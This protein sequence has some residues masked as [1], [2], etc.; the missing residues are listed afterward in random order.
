MA[1][2]KT[3]SKNTVNSAN[4]FVFQILGPVVDVKFSED[5]I[6]MI[7]DALVVDNNGVELVLEVEQHMGDEVVRTIAMGP[8][9]GLAK[10]LPVINTNAPIQAPVGDDVLGRMFNVTGH[11]IDEKPEFTGKRMPIHR[12]APAYEE[13]ITNAEILETGIKV[14]DLMIPFAKGGKIGLFGGA[15]VGKTVLIQELINNIAKAHSGVS[16]FA[17]VGERTR[18]GNDLYHEFIEAGVLDKTSLVFGQ[19]NE[20]PG[21]RMRVA[22]TGLTIAE[23]FR[24]EKNMDVLLFI[25]NI[26][27]FTQAGSEVSALLGRMPSAVGYQPTLS[28]EMGALQERI[29]STNK[30]SITS[31]QAVYVPADDLT[32]PAPATTFTHL[33]AKIVLDRSIASLGIYPAVDPLSSSSRMLDP[34][35]IGEEHYNVALGVQGTLQK[36][37]D[38]QSI[39]AILGM[40]ELSAE[41]KLIVQ[42]ARK[43]R[44]FLSQ[45]FFVGEKF[46]GR[47]GQ[48]V[49]VSDTVR[50][51]KMILDGEMDDI[52]EIL[53]LYKG[54]AEDVIQ[55]YNE[56]K[57]KNKK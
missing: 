4:G 27:R 57:V 11:A 12:D 30:G 8:T 20:P 19:M 2:K 29:T 1:A 49:K 52:P 13:L 21:A 31:V 39:I 15:G 41:D 50:S 26:F 33:D 22:L 16:V 51:F 23:H 56:T 36:Y 53:F 14:I 48:Y 32:D 24:D 17:G 38:L 44:N 47:P 5:N 6:P 28:T 18:E 43:I 35:I 25:D 7:Y 55:A 37:Q 9:E 45:S 34:E 10:G 54:T 40:D 3:T 46:T 42:R